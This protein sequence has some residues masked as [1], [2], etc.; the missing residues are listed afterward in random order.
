MEWQSGGFVEPPLLRRA[1]ELAVAAEIARARLVRGEAVSITEVVKLEN[2]AARAW[3]DLQARRGQREHLQGVSQAVALDPKGSWEGDLASAFVKKALEDLR[4]GA[5]SSALQAARDAVILDPKVPGGYEVLSKIMLPGEDYYELLQRFHDW[6]KPN[7][8]IEIGVNTGISLSLAKSPTVVIGIDP[9]PRLLQSPRTICKFF[10]LKSDDY[11][12]TRDPRFDI[13]AETVDLTFID[14]LHLIE[15]VLRD[16]INIERFSS[17]TTLV[18]IHDCFA[19]DVLTADRECKTGFWSGDVWKIIPCL[20][21][22]RPDLKVFTIATA[23]T[24]LAVVSHLDSHSTVLSDRF[25][26]IVS[27][28]VPLEVDPDERRRREC[29]AM[30]PNSWQEVLAQLSPRPS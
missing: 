12:A 25:D 4:S 1:A 6:L 16:F 13:E 18:L 14:G 22:F 10:P 8:Y 19:I 29:A 26:D 15:Q 24:G 27:R 30:V 28:Y 9:E 23:P 21:E 5:K 7:S 17:P 20:R 2:L 11:F 3:R